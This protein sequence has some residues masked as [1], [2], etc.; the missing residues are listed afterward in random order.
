LP[1]WDELLE[2]HDYRWVTPHPSVVSL[3]REMDNR[4]FRKILDLGCGAGRHT[5]YLSGLGFEVVG[6]DPA[7]SG[8]EH[9]YGELVTRELPRRLVLAGMERL[10]FHDSSYQCVVS[11]YV[12]HHNSILGITLAI[13]E[14]ERI[15][16]PGGLFLATVLGRKDFKYGVGRRVEDGTYVPTEG[17]E[18][19]VVHHFFERDEI[20]DLLGSFRIISLAGDEAEVDFPGGKCVR[21]D[22]WEVLAEKLSL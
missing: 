12:I 15:L 10:P 14:I 3:Q 13:G 16:V 11:T 6:L 7:S 22:H 9:C 5:T 19:G 2:R 20:M 18:R 8:L 4:G 1:G 17:D 21:H